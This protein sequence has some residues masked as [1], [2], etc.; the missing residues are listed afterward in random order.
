MF[1]LGNCSR[2]KIVPCLLLSK[3]WKWET[4]SYE[5]SQILRNPIEK[6]R[7]VGISPDLHTNEREDIRKMIEVAK[8]VHIDNES[9][10]VE[11]YRFLVVHSR[12]SPKSDKDQK[13]QCFCP[14]LTLR[15]EV[16][17]KLTPDPI[18][19]L[20]LKNGFNLYIPDFAT[21]NIYLM[22]SIWHT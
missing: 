7:G 5:I 2:K 11:N 10:D 20:I 14:R 6:F 16:G 17:V 18:N 13:K 4:L 21:F 1:R 3:N 19:C 9:E 12:E 8:Q 22:P 15:R